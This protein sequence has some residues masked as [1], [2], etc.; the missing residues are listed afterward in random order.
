[1]YR[2]AVEGYG[3]YGG[4]WEATEGYGGLGGIRMVRESWGGLERPVEG[5]T[6]V[7]TTFV[8]LLL[9]LGN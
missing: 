3:A 7:F 6:D 2:G 4:L 5:H 9:Y 8:V 1:M